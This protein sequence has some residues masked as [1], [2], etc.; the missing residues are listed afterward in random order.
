MANRVNVDLDMNV[1]GYVDGMDKATQSTAAYETT[2][3][4]VKDEQLNL[5]KELRKAKTDAKNLAATYALLDKQAKQS[6]FGREIAK[7]LEEAKQKAAELIDINSDLQEELKNRASDTATFDAFVDGVSGLTSGL[8]AA[9]GVLGIFTKNT[10]TMTRA[11]TLFTTAESIASAAIK[12]KNLLQK[13][14]SLMLAI[15]KI[16]QQALTAAT[17]EGTAATQ[18]ATIA[19]RAFNLVAKANPYV[20]LFTGLTAVIGAIGTYVLLTNKAESATEKLKKEMHETSLQAQKDAQTE[21]TKLDLLYKA[22]QN[23]KLAIDDRRR[24]AE[25]MQDLYPAVFSDYT[26]EEILV[27]KAADAY[28]K[29]RQ[30]ILE[31]AIARAY[32]DKITEKAKENIDLEDQ[33]EKAEKELEKKRKQRNSNQGGFTPGAYSPAA[34]AG[35]LWDLQAA[36]DNVDE[37]KNKLK[38]NN[39]AMS[40][41]Q[42][43]IN[44]TADAQR[45]L[46]KENKVVA[47]SISDIT[48]K[49]N[50]LKT[51]FSNGLISKEDYNKQKAELDKQLKLAQAGTDLADKGGGGGGGKKD[52]KI[53]IAAE[54]LAAYEKELADLQER[55][56]KGALPEDLKD[57][58]KLEAKIQELQ[59][60]IKE[61]KIELG[62]ELP[63]TIES[64]EKRISEL[65]TM[66]K[67][68]A[69]PDDL[70]DPKKFIAEINRLQAEVKEKKIEFGFEKPDTQLQKLQKAITDAQQKYIIAVDADDKSAQQAALEEYY[71]AQ[72]TLDEYKLKITIEPRI[73]D[74][75]VKKQRNEI[76]KIVQEAYKPEDQ[77]FDFSGLSESVQKEANATLE[78]F[79]KI[80]EARDKLVEI[81]NNPNS[82][83]TQ[84]SAAQDG[85]DSLSD[86]Y[87]TLESIVG[88]YQEMSDAAIKVAE[89]NK[90]IS[91]GV[92]SI[93]N[94]VQAAGEMF[95]ALGKLTQNKGL[96]TTG[97]IAEAVATVAL[98]FARALTTAKTWVDWLAFGLSGAATMINLIAQI[99]S[100]TAGAY[101]QGG[102]VGGSSFSGDRLTARVN[103]GEMILN[104]RQQKNLFNL[105]DNDAMPKA[106]G[107]NVQV[108]GVIH[109]TDLLLVQKNTNKIL[110][111]TGNKINF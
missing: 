73:S 34:T 54:S 87:N 24:A 79:N 46:S 22:T 48:N 51:K 41:Y 65:Q 55:A 47:G 83:D 60:K 21:I 101:A 42:D 70:K 9:T 67:K 86:S 13:Q 35:E 102:I 95:S 45:I 12:A 91:E 29:L 17:V 111:K 39:A 92:N 30:A 10:E 43:K 64:L 103:S 6:Q 27:G 68:G 32:Q 106:G 71:A 5:N 19:Q 94:A 26:T 18:G 74:E 38:E 84:I 105:L 108:T 72:K 52:V 109:G 58:K 23:T 88:K 82:S 96:Q 66:A 93:G 57:P 20:L 14:S 76:S 37:L 81:M 69:L 89:N 28:K 3:K 62:I 53:E 90:K 97:L 100:A 56:K 25:Q 85:I 15:N 104:Q 7:Q 4:K 11:I 61:K 8:S 75:E 80:K 36:Q 77:K 44:E 98:S 1:Q 40:S 31:V 33:L 107:T 50:K 78:Q 110:N 99:K 63:D 16:Q 2:T 49:I 59:D